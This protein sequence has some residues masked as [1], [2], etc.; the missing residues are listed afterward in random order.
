MVTNHLISSNLY[1]T[2]WGRDKMAAISQTI[3]SKAF[4]W[5]KM[6]EFWLR[7]HWIMFQRVQLTI[8]QHWFGWWLGAGQATSHYLNQWCLVYW[9]IYASLGLN[10]LREVCN[11]MQCCFCSHY[12]FPAHMAS[13]A[14]L[15][16]IQCGAIW[17]IHVTLNYSRHS[18]LSA[19]SARDG[20]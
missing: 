15:K 18:T 19:S 4:S 14:E 3:I 9:R 12:G 6:F 13:N 10:E 17:S 16:P 1:L 11:A 2:H 7:F 5:M 20:D 8:F